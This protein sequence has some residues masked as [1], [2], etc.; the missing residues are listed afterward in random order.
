[1]SQSIVVGSTVRNIQLVKSCNEHN[2]RQVRR[3]KTNK[4]EENTAQESDHPTT[5]LESKDCCD[6]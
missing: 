3:L 5:V 4:R 1:M 6:I 2:K